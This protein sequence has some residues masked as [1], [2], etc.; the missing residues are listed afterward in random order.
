VAKAWLQRRAGRPTVTK[1]AMSESYAAGVIAGLL[2]AD[3]HSA[4]NAL[5][6]AWRRARRPKLRAFL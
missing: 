1:T 5:P 6:E 3:A 4:R 2:L